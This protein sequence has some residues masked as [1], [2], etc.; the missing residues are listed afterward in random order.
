MGGCLGLEVFKTPLRR[1]PI[2]MSFCVLA[3]VFKKDRAGL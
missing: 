1:E 2:G 3:S